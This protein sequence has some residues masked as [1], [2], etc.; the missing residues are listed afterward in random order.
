[1]KL[2]KLFSAGALMLGAVSVASAQDEA[3][4]KNSMNMSFGVKAGFNF[5]TIDGDNI[6]SANARTS[7]HAGAF[8]EF[9]IADIFS[10]QVEALYSGQGA[11]YSPNSPLLGENG[12]ILAEAGNYNTELQLDYINVPLLAKFYIFEGFSVE[13]GPQFSFL[14][15][16]EFDSKPTDGGGDLPSPF[17]KTANTFEF[18]MAGGVS[19]QTNMGLFATARYIRGLSDIADE[20]DLNNAVFQVGLGYKF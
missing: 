17:R 12:E 1:M 15:N 8:V 4:N 11:E 16:D 3:T 2:F 20:V 19:F 14:L 5:A 6:E 13:A 10:I 9:P 7:F 18:G